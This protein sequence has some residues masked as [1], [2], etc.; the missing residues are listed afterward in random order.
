MPAPLNID[1][2]QVKM[3]ALSI[4]LRP[5]A[6]QLNI[7]LPTLAAWSSK[8]KWFAKP[9]HALPPT[10]KPIQTLQT[11]PADVLADMLA[12]DSK[13]TKLSLARASRKAAEHLADAEPGTVLKHSRAM[14]DVAKTAATV[15]GWAGSTEGKAG[16]NISMLTGQVAIQYKSQD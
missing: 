7:P 3:L 1:R 9:E 4:G 12:D 14:H 16:V 2:E 15:H 13:Q 8:G 10:V 6:K 11:K 5:A